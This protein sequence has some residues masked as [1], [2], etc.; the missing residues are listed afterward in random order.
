MRLLYNSRIRE[1]FMFAVKCNICSILISLAQYQRPVNSSQMRI[2]AILLCC[3]LLLFT[4]FMMFVYWTIYLLISFLLHLIYVHFN[5]LLGLSKKFVN[6]CNFTLNNEPFSGKFYNILILKL[7]SICLKIRA[8]ELLLYK[9]CLIVNRP[10]G[11][12]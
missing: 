10:D 11:P 5:K 1:H 7:K 8:L 2:S 3:N 6:T 4:F 12:L 9:H